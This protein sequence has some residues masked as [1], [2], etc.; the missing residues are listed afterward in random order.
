MLV[1]DRTLVPTGGLADAVDRAV[2]GGV[3]A[4][5]LREKDLA[6][7]ELIALGREL[8]AVTRGRALLLVN[9]TLAQAHACDADGLHLP[10]AAPP[11]APDRHSAFRI[12]HSAFLLGR[13]VH[14]VDA[15]RRAAAERVDYLVLGTVFPSR[16]HPGGATGGLDLVRHV[17]AAVDVPIVAIGGITAANAASVLRAG[18]SGVAVISAILAAPDPRAAAAE[19]RAAIDQ[20]RAVASGEHA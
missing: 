7:G 2:A 10:E 5:Q 19:L 18:A 12:P 4:V 6:D 16:S 20:A 3:D 11:V 15:A 17:R 14:D 13:S 9:G 1:T 8:R